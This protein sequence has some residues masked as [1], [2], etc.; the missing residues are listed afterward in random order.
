MRITHLGAT[1]TYFEGERGR[2]RPTGLLTTTMGSFV[3]AGT[4]TEV[5]TKLVATYIAGTYAQAV[6]SYS[7]VHY[8]EWYTDRIEG[9]RAIGDLD[10]DLEGEVG[11]V[12]P[13]RSYH[14]TGTIEPTRASSSAVVRPSQS[15]SILP[16]GVSGTLSS[17]SPPALAPLQFQE[18]EAQEGHGGSPHG[19]RVLRPKEVRVTGT[20]ANFIHTDGGS[21]SE[22]YSVFTGTYVAASKTF[23]FFFGNTVLSPSGVKGVPP[24][25]QQQTILVENN[26]NNVV[27]QMSKNIR[28]IVPGTKERATIDGSING[29]AMEGV[30]VEIEGS[31][32]S[33]GGLGALS[34]EEELIMIDGAKRET[35][36]PSDPRIDS[37]TVT[38]ARI[39]GQAM[40]LGKGKG[41]VNPETGR[42]PSEDTN[43]VPTGRR[44]G[45]AE[46]LVDPDNNIFGRGGG[47]QGQGVNP[48]R[49]TPTMTLP[50]FT[51][52]KVWVF[53]GGRGRGD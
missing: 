32:A 37:V 12:Y 29:E 46:R 26:K 13:T 2:S 36:T 6:S 47:G 21:G 15:S 31:E 45:Q 18:E 39:P 49:P 19:I 38:L 51:L 23:L 28:V 4:T 50:T 20:H 48:S 53:W 3:T 7:N 1:T 44:I 35:P 52:S 40:G 33:S 30:M 41:R 11:Q 22:T 8:P 14:E 43:E 24:P 34:Q 5:I 17:R 42:V 27:V 9:T 25:Q 10:L 16:L